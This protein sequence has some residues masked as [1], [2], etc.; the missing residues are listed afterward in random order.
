MQ[1]V[2]LT[3]NTKVRIYLTLPEFCVT[4]KVTWEYQMEDSTEGR[5]YMIL[6]RDLLTALN[7]EFKILNIK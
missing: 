1:A 5:Y 2:N 3:T 7:L 6:G 4:K